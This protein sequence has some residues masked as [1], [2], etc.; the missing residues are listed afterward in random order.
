MKE[1]TNERLKKCI[2]VCGA[3]PPQLLVAVYDTIILS[4]F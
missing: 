2:S 1:Q 3:I 4:Q